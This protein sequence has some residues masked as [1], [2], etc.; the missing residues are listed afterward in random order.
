MAVPSAGEAL[1]YVRRRGIRRACTKFLTGYLLGRERWYLTIEDLRQW[2]GAPLRRTD[3]EFRAAR[4]DDLPLMAPFTARQHPRTLRAWLGPDYFF[5]I[6]LADGRPVT[7]R[8]LGRAVAR[9]VEGV[10]QLGRHQLFVV[11]EFTVPSHRRRG[12]TRQLAIAT[13]PPLI[14]RGFR[15]VVGIHSIDNENTIAATRAKGIATIGTLSCLRVAWKRWFAYESTV[16]V[17]A[18]LAPSV[19]SKSSLAA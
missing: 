18:P 8:C 9:T 4:V 14:A 6:A 1:L 16:A 17:P 12:I 7:Y 3:L 11:D 13:N 15:E 10:I 5:F 2:V 19:R